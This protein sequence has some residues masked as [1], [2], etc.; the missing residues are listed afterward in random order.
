MEAVQFYTTLDIERMYFFGEYSKEY[1]TCDPIKL[2]KG[3]YRLI[4][5]ELFR[6]DRFNCP[7]IIIEPTP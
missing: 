3:E 7:P 6:V 2:E 4:G 1:P 5:N